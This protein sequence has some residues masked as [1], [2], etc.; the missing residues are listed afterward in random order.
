M[1]DNRKNFSTSVI[2][3]FIW[4]QKELASYDRLALITLWSQSDGNRKVLISPGK[5]ARL[6][7][8]APETIFTIL[9]KL[10]RHNFIELIKYDSDRKIELHLL[11]PQES[12]AEI[13]NKIKE[14]AETDAETDKEDRLVSA[15]KKA[16]PG[17]QLTPSDFTH[18]TAYLERGMEVELLE[19]LIGYTSRR[20][21]GNPVSYLCTVLSSLYDENITTLAEYQDYRG[22]Q[23]KNGG[24]ISGDPEKKE[25][26]DKLHDIEELTKR[27]WN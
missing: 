3:E 17:R 24:Q 16:F 21:S 7:S 5:F 27:D 12:Q 15:W 11:L 1:S 9:K 20:A 18:L 2:P 10:D 26:Q 13:E 8:I 23:K 19:E 25:E 6:T 4:R 22:E 14:G